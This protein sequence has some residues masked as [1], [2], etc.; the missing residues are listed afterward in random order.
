MGN[1]VSK[2][3]QLVEIKDFL[4][5]PGLCHQTGRMECWPPARSAYGSEKIL[6]V[7][8]ELNYFNCKKL[9]QTHQSITPSFHHS[10]SERSELT[11]I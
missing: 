8:E 1:D 6:G 3:I 9:L 4:I 11:Y 2:I 7:R 5:A 10:D